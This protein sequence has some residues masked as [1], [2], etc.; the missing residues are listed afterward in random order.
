L[1]EAI[2]VDII[3]RSSAHI[4]SIDTKKLYD[5]DKPRVEFKLF[6]IKANKE[7]HE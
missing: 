1:V 7:E 3:F 4:A 5:N 6:E 2:G